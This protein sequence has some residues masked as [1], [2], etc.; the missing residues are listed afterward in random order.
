[1]EPI[2]ENEHLSMVITYQHYSKF[3]QW[4]CQMIFWNKK[5]KMILFE[6]KIKKKKK[7]ATNYFIQQDH[8]HDPGYQ[9]LIELIS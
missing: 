2:F 8:M 6:I 1:L 9:N 3:K 7:E 5:I 4:V